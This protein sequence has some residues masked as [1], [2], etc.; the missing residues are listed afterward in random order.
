M[1]SPT[2]WALAL[3]ILAYLTT[4]SRCSSI[5]VIFSMSSILLRFKILLL[6][7]IWSLCFSNANNFSLKCFTFS[8]SLLSFTLSTLISYFLFIRSASKTLTFFPLPLTLATSYDSTSWLS[9]IIYFLFSSS[10]FSIVFIFFTWIC[11][12]LS[13]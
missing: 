4:L 12:N 1:S 7:S 6:V 8:C 9:I 13:W 3:T 2:F 5:L 11:T 10:Y